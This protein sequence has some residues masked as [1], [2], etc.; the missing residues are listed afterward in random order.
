MTRA[1]ILIG[2]ARAKLSHIA[3]NSVRCVI[4]SPPYWNLRD[5]GT[6]GQIGREQHPSDYIRELA[7]V[8]M[9]ASRTLTDDGTIWINIGDTYARKMSGTIKEKD[10]VGVPWRL[11]FELQDR[12]LYLRQEIIWQK[13]NVMP[14]SIKD[15][16]TRSHETIFMFSKKPRYFYD[17]KAILEPV[18]EVSLKRA[19]LGWKS[20][21]IT[22]KTGPNGINVEKMGT[23]FVNPEGRNKR[24]VWT[25]TPA[26]FSGA[27]FA[28][29][30]EG[31]VEP[32]VLAC[33]EPGD[34]ILDPFMGAGTVGLVAIKNDRHFIGIELSEE[35]A[36]L[37]RRRIETE[38]ATEVEVLK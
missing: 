30:P 7:D 8:F 20:D 10:L 22:T 32:P 31:I 36:E 29:M 21:R 4:T 25:V 1:K 14:E 27:H 23:R 6:D 33:S 34:I 38:V 15:R 11:A 16:C 26:R 17:H 24:S 28:V 19:Q 12:G 2:D 18:S 9:E 13:P 5:Y 37:S 35:Y 3:D